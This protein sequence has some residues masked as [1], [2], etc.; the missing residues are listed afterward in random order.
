[1]EEMLNPLCRGRWV[2]QRPASGVQ[3]SYRRRMLAGVALNRER[4]Q[5]PSGAIS[6][7]RI[8]SAHGVTDTSI[9]RL[10]WDLRWC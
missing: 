8:N 2:M 7:G 6:R 10:E 9:L 5:S 1:V 4:S 3:R